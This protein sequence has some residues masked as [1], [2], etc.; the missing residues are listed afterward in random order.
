[1]IRNKNHVS[2]PE[3]TVFVPNHEISQFAYIYLMSLCKVNII[4]N[5][6]FSWWGAYLNQHK[7][8]LV[9]A[10]S[11]WTFTSNKTLAL[12]SWTKI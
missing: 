8:Q 12:D 4:S 6:T 10:P 3:S 5:S 7:N 9:I 2:L 1:M 11:R